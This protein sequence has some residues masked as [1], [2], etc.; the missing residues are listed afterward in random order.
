MGQ[1]KYEE[2]LMTLLH[3]KY[4]TLKTKTKKKTNLKTTIRIFTLM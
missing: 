1:L 3:M 4:I 2:V